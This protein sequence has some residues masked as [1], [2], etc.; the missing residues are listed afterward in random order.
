[1]QHQP[2]GN[3]T[4]VYQT[5]LYQL[6]CCILPKAKYVAYYATSLPISYV[7]IAASMGKDLKYT[8]SIHVLASHPG[9]LIFFN[10]RVH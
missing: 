9:S 6:I 3:I 1:M 10:I 4:C 2:E 7:V 5:P 8:T